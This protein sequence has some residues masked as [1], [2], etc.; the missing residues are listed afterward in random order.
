VRMEG[1]IGRDLGHEKGD[2]KT[3]NRFD[4]NR[5]KTNPGDQYLIN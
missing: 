1:V 5:T 4:D 3:L 2:Q